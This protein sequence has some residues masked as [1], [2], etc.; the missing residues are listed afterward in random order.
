VV[1]GDDLSSQGVAGGWFDLDLI[2]DL[3]SRQIVGW[4]VHESDSADYTALAEGI[5]AATAKPLLHGD[6]GSTLKA[7]TVLAMLTGW[8]MKQPRSKLRGIWWHHQSDS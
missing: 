3:Y 6:N 1:R 4:E 7:T 2:L 8:A 5:H